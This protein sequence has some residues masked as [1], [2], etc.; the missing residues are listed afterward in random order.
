MI[1]TK[2]RNFSLAL[3]LVPVFFNSTAAARG[4]AGIGNTG[5]ISIQ[6]EFAREIAVQT[7]RNVSVFDLFESAPQPQLRDLYRS[8][9]DS[10]YRGAVLTEF[11]LLEKIEDGNQF[12]AL[13]RRLPGKI[14][15]S[16]TE[17]ERLSAA[18]SL[19][20]GLLVAVILHEVGH[21]CSING[22]P[23]GDSYDQLL[24]QLALE[25]H[26]ASRRISAGVFRDLEFVERVKRR[27][28]VSFQQ[29]SPAARES[30]AISYLNYV[31]DWIYQRF[32]ERFRYRPAPASDFYAT[33]DTSLYP[34][35]NAINLATNSTNREINAVVY[36][37]LR[38]SF[39]EKSLATYD[40]YQ[41]QPLPTDLTCS[42]DHD[43]VEN[44]QFATCSL[45]VYWHELPVDSLKDFR[46]Q[47]RFTIN[48]LGIVRI[49][50][51]RFE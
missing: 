2:L 16:R 40:S 31:G 45:T 3:A 13:A 30:I 14:Q 19:N 43:R 47:L 41:R 46:Q 32:E 17:M 42:I 21:D 10:M 51:M 27:Q 18:G 4:V 6:F 25:L 20:T 50:G 9:R 33:A 1:T 44:L 38:A 15:I 22:N 7:L 48:S 26:R 5:D 39:E 37:V 23:V 36:G 29:L 34:G 11:E 12:H 24:N 8:C 35:W 49:M 28:S